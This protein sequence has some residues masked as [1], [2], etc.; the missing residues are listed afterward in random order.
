[1]NLRPHLSDEALVDLMREGDEDAF[2]S[3]YRRRQPDI[4]KF[5]F[6]MSNSRIITEDV[7]QE[8]FINLIRYANR[9]DP[10]RGSVRSF[11]YGIARN[12][13]LQHFE[14][15]RPYIPY[16]GEIAENGFTASG[17]GSRAENNPL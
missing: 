4:H 10:T 9:F 14:R 2:V 3:L 6:G 8:V 16:E 1:M 13:L 12:C 11:L 7:M 15:E 5:V 17:N